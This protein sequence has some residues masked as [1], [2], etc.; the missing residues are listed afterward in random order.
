M[1]TLCAVDSRERVI[2]VYL[3]RLIHFAAVTLHSSAAV[4]HLSSI[5]ARYLGWHKICSPLF[6]PISYSYDV[7][8]GSHFGFLVHSVA[9][10]VV[11]VHA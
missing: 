8:L 1:T 5:A 9:I 6:V 3:I 2:Q 4:D 10:I 11:V 7:C